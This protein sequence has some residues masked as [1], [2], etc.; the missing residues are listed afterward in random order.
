MLLLWCH[1]L[2]TSYKG[3]TGSFQSLKRVV[4]TNWTHRLDLSNKSLVVRL[5]PCETK[6][7]WS[8][9]MENTSRR[10]YL[11]IRKIGKA[12][13]SCEDW[14]KWRGGIVYRQNI[15]TP[16]PWACWFGGLCNRPT[17]P[18]SLS[19]FAYTIR[20]VAVCIYTGCWKDKTVGRGQTHGI[21]LF[22]IFCCLEHNARPFS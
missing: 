2:A 7:T 18:Y 11:H 15:A 17:I 3:N 12:S 16:T 13:C 22:I 20:G 14:N 9:D 10:T 19:H 6:Q 4:S 8:L 1:L 5:L 21:G